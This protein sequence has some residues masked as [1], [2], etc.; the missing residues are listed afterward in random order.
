MTATV[1]ERPPLPRP[2]AAAQTLLQLVA[3]AALLVL[4]TIGAF[5]LGR[6][7]ADDSTTRA[8]TVQPVTQV[9]PVPPALETCRGIG[10]GHC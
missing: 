6:S 3:V 1:V 10:S 5:A 9:Q 7:T 8:V 4:L 2:P